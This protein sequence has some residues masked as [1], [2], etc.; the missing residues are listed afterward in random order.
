MIDLEMLRGISLASPPTAGPIRLLEMIG[1]DFQRNT[2]I[3]I[4]G[5][6]N[7][8]GD[9]PVFLAMNHTDR[10]SYMPLMWKLHRLGHPRYPA[11]WVKGKYFKNPLMRR[12]FLFTGTIPIPSRGYLISVQLQQRT[13]APPD[14]AVYRALRDLVDGDDAAVPA[15]VAELVS[16]WGGPSVFAATIRRL[17]ADMMHEVI[18]LHREALTTGQRHVLVYPEG[19]R[20]PRLLPGRTGLAQ[21]SQA[22]GLP[23]VPIACNG[24]D[25]LY[26]GD[27]PI[28]KGGRVVY[29]IG[30]PLR[31]D[32]P[33]LAAHRVSAPFVPF[34]PE[35]ARAHG[36]QFQAATD[37][38][39]SRIAAM[40]EPQYL[41]DNVGGDS[42][43]GAGAERFL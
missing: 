26:P 6:D 27:I 18:R 29:R 28:S 40:L 15:E 41:P 17:F 10:F 43:E 20:S 37:V 16:G 22:M 1:R 13:G 21:V 3:V 9:E 11:T 8:P 35:A 5:A 34:S 24:G 25:V 14:P 23:I 36:A 19:T 31:V 42:D 32:D 33:A 7:L 39:M 2:E 30:K 4:E 38:V 12:L